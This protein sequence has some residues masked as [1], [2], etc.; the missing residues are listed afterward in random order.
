[1]NTTIPV[2]AGLLPLVT[3]S[4]A[5]PLILSSGLALQNARPGALSVPKPAPSASARTLAPISPEMRN[6]Q[7]QLADVS[8]RSGSGKL[9][10]S[11]KTQPSADPSVHAQMAYST[12]SGSQSEPSYSPAGVYGPAIGGDA[13][14]N[15]AVGGPVGPKKAFIRF[16]AEQS[17]PLVSVTL[18]FLSADY[19]GYGGGTG[20]NWTVQLHADDGTANHFPVGSPLATKSVNAKSTSSAASITS[21][22]SGY[23]T[24]AGVIYHLVIENVDPNPTV[25][26]FSINNWVRLSFTEGG[27]LNP[28]CADTDWGAGYYHG[29]AWHNCAGACPIADLAYGNGAHQ[30]MCYG[31]ASYCCPPGESACSA[32]QLVGQIKGSTRMVRERFT[33]SGGDRLV[34]GVGIRLLRMSGAASDLRVSLRNSAG[35]E[36]DFAMIPASSVAIGPAPS[37]SLPASWNDLGQNARWVTANFNQLHMLTN[38]ETYHLQFSCTQGTYWAWVIRRLTAEYGYSPATAFADGW[39]EYTADGTTWNPLGRVRQQNDL[40][41]YFT[42]YQS[43]GTQ[44]AEEEG[45]PSSPSPFQKKGHDGS[46]ALLERAGMSP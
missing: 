14:G 38:G 35:T 24:T 21:F 30:G 9:V 29:G 31:E 44:L 17:S 5:P 3:L 10:A 45:D 11:A 12:A 15:I 37:Y 13:L 42:T 39:A 6:R 16:R 33:V 22:T 23:S 25:N 8:P 7:G 32:D 36:V 27:S 34:G 28:R 20:G 18:P 40:Q 2:F 1:M 46:H 26:F 19:P 4:F 43:N 41:F